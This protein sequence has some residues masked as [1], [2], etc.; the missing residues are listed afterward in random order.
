MG[1]PGSQTGGTPGLFA[2]VR[3]GQW[4]PEVRWVSP[5]RLWLMGRIA[6]VA[7]LVAAEGK[8]EE[9]QARL[10]EHFERVQ[11]EEGTMVFSW[12][13][14][15]RNPDAFWAYEVYASRE[16][17]AVHAEWAAGA[18]EEMADLLASA[19]EVSFCRPL[20]A[21]GLPE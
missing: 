9:L 3:F 21:K 15:F 12:Q 4:Q 11:D 6:V 5:S 20:M 1:P 13:V 18:V 10:T 2:A 19:P 14:D 17:L 16:A 8:R 7:K